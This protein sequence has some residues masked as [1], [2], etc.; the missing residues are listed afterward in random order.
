MSIKSLFNI[1]KED[2]KARHEDYNSY[3]FIKFYVMDINFRV[4]VRYRIQSYLSK[5][6]KLLR[7]VSILIRNGNIK[8]YGVEIGINTD[9]QSGLNIHHINGIVIGDGVEIGKN[10]N[11][12]Q[13]VT[14]G[15]K[16]CSY[17]K[18]GNNVTLYPGTIILGEINIHD[19]AIVGANSVVIKD[20]YKNQVVAGSPAQIK[21]KRVVINEKE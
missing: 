18:I 3:K 9:I 13:Q 8:K 14:I 20:V 17:P 6:N 10:L 19:N 15:R 11:I 12:F 5:K 2:F 21:T 7:L 1:I 4:V 16:K